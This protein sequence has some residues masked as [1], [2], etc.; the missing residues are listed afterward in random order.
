MS[1]HLFFFFCLLAVRAY[2]PFKGKDFQKWLKILTVF[3]IETCRL[4]LLK[5][6]LNF[7]DFPGQTHWPTENYGKHESFGI[8]FVIS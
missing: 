8:S 2:T 3:L 1:N 5:L 7:L 6:P 4:S